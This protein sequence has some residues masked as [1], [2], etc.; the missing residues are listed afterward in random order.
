MRERRAFTLIELLVTIGIISIVVALTISA[1]IAA[2]GAARR[3]FCA[4]NL[5]QIGL[6]IYSY[7]STHNVLPLAYG[8]GGN[9]FSFLVQILPYVDQGQLY[10]SINMNKGADLTLRSAHLA[11]YL[12]PG[13]GLVRSDPAG[14]T[15]YAGNQGTGFQQGVYDGAFSILDPISFANFTDGTSNTV[16]V[17]EWLTGHDSGTVRDAQ[18]S[19]FH[20][21]I[22]Y[23]NKGE[24]AS[25]VAACSTLDPG[26]ARL[27]PPRIGIPWTHGDYG[28]SLYNHLM[29]INRLNCLNGTNHQTGAWTAKGNHN[30]GVNVLIA[31]GHVR[32]VSDKVT[33]ATW[34]ALGS[35]N[36][37]E[38]AARESY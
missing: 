8:G 27:A 26:T 21:P 3:S 1:V 23:R 15:N 34:T 7:A 30:H 11:I 12:C 29:T 14:A 25:F 18:R 20:T 32:F 35:R 17:S 9:G 5:K 2:R 38:P 36:G 31:D 13:D 16:A 22:A 10:N 24:R 28:H 33:P 19:V 4:N 6:G 37:A